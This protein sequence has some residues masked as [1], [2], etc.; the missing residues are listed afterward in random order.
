MFKY[1]KPDVLIVTGKFSRAAGNF[2]AF[3]FLFSNK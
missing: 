1:D 2:T 3:C